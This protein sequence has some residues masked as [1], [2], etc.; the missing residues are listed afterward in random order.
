MAMINRNLLESMKSGLFATRE[1]EEI[2]AEANEQNQGQ[3]VILTI[4]A[5][6][7]RLKDWVSEEEKPE[8]RDDGSISDLCWSF[9][10]F[11]EAMDDDNATDFTMR[12]RHEE[13]LRNQVKTGV[14][15]KTLDSLHRGFLAFDGTQD[16][17][18]RIVSEAYSER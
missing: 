11:G 4:N 18:E 15:V 10:F 8:N 6:L 12:F 14:W 17:W 5:L 2:M 7:E 3:L 16:E 13:L 1:L 9:R